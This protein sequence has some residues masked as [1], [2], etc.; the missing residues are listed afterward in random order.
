MVRKTIE[1]GPSCPD[2]LDSGRM[3]TP[4]EAAAIS[5]QSLRTIY[6]WVEAGEVHFIEESTGL[7]I[8]VG[9]LPARSAEGLPPVLEGY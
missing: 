4:T 8:C 3:V 1:K 6:R 9:S 2:C 5:A 7:L